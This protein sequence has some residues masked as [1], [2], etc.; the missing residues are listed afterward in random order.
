MKVRPSPWKTLLIL[1]I[2]ML[3]GAAI[4]FSFTF[5]LFIKPIN[6]WGWPPY[7]ILGIW[8]LL[9]VGLCLVTFLFSY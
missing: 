7:V 6:E 9:S 8:L 1:V 4:I 2:V 3:V 5:N